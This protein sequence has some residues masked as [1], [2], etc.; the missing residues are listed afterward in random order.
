MTLTYTSSNGNSYNLR[1]SVI[2]TRRADFN[3]FKWLPQTVGRQYGVYVK[4]FNRDPFQFT[5][6]L[7][8]A[9]SLSDKMATLNALHEAFDHDILTMTP[10]R[11]SVGDYYVD[12]YITFSSTYY[13]K[14]WT[15]NE[16]TAY[17]PYPFWQK[18]HTYS[19]S[20]EAVGTETVTNPGAGAAEFILTIHGP[21]TTSTCW[22]KC[23]DQ[24]I[25]C[26]VELDTGDKVVINSRDKTVLAYYNSLPLVDSPVDAFTTRIKEGSIFQKIPSGS[27]AVEW[28]GD[29]TF[30]M[31]VC[32]ERSE[33]LWT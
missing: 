22:I 6:L 18:N 5:I 11:L 8:I 30:E 3:T 2:R 23:N 25:G 33:P 14:P 9:G 24:K 10:G 4:Q 27:S 17:C 26:Q 32:E 29:M 20:G 1:G 16:I 19:F 7:D 15:Q 31:I 21:T 13:Q 28:N 12:C